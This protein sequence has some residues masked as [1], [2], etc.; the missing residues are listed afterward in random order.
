[1]AGPGFQLGSFSTGLFSGAQNIFSLYKEYQGVKRQSERDAADA[2]LK[3]AQ[4]EDARNRKA[5][6]GARSV[7]GTQDFTQAPGQTTPTQTPASTPTVAPGAAGQPGRLG[8][9]KLNARGPTRRRGHP[10]LIPPRPEYHPQR[11]V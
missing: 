2:A 9:E 7:D 6:T 1:M 10:S 11:A 5:G 4:E 8:E 3:A